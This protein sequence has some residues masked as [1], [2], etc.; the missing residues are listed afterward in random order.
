MQIWV[1]ADACPVVIREIL[2]R[3][4]T[5]KQIP[6]TFVANTAI[7]LPRSP[8]LKTLVVSSGFDVADKE[9]VNRAVSGDIVITADIPLAAELVDNGAL[10]LNPR[11][12]LYTRETIKA[13]LGM[14]DFMETMRASG[15][16]GE[17]QRPQ[18]QGDRKAFADTLDRLLAKR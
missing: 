16:H 2:I 9:I 3:A 7:P 6:V 1:D 17:G 13:R 4:A 12:E 5:R 8:L 14:R 11:G 10:A 18:G 15:I